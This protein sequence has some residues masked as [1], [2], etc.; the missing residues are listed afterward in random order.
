MAFKRENK[1]QWTDGH[2]GRLLVVDR[3]SGFS[4]GT[5][6]Q[7]TLQADPTVILDEVSLFLAGSLENP[8]HSKFC[9]E[10]ETPTQ[11]AALQ[12]SFMFLSALHSGEIQACQKTYPRFRMKLNSKNIL[13]HLSKLGMQWA[14]LCFISSQEIVLFFLF[15]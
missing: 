9:L 7:H 4:P 10:R 1:E 6:M 13:L 2:L 5:C 14:I 8:F 11:M 12:L 3:G 15:G